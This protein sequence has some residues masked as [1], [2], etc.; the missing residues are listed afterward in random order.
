MSDFH[1][2]GR[3]WATTVFLVNAV[4]IDSSPVDSSNQSDGNAFE[5]HIIPVV[6]FLFAS[7]TDDRFIVLPT[8]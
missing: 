3:L 6:H 1:R 8:F 5:G 2:P 7:Q 4:S